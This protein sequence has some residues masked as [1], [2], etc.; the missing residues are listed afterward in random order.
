MNEAAR[1][2]FPNYTQ[3]PGLLPLRMWSA[4]RAASVAGAL[5]LA[6]LLWLSPQAGLFVLWHLL[7][8]LLPALFLL[9]PGLW[10][11]LCPLAAANQVPRVAGF[12]C[13]LTHT[14]TIREYSYVIGMLA[15]FAVVSAR[16]IAFNNNG[17][18]AALLVFGA[19]LLAFLGVV[20]FKGKSGWCSSI[21]PLLPVQRLYGQTPFV[22][23]ANAHCRPCVGCAKN[24]YDFNPAVASL[25]DQ[26]DHDPHYV[27]HRR[28]FAAVFPGFML[29]FYA[30]PQP[31]AI[32]VA[33]LYLTFAAYMGASLALFA[34]LET[35]VKLRNN[36]LTALF[37]AAAFNIYYWFNSAT[38]VDTVRRLTHAGLGAGWV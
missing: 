4:L 19:L 30:T 31:P 21:C 25:A 13:G 7:I 6:A 8:P 34:T 2:A 29:A 35:F 17:V 10:R 22:T 5:A 14:R 15:L 20:L 9:A 28:F 27:G 12:T 16:K 23:I 1:P 3:L 11:N 26:Y 18:A 36:A 33:Q 32:G 24:C 38:L 37:A